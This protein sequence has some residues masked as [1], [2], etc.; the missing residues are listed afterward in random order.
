ML[1]GALSSAYFM[2][3]NYRLEREH[4]SQNAIASARALTS[5]VDKDLA[6]IESGLRVLSVSP[7]LLN[8]DL[9]TFYKFTKD[10]L[11]Y[12]NISNYVLLDPKGRQVLNTLRDFGEA[13]PQTGNPPV[14]QRI[15]DS[16]QTVLTDLFTG[17]V[18]GKPILAMGVPVFK[19]GQAIYSINVGIFPER[20]SALMMRQRLPSNWIC[21]ILDSEGKI[22]VESRAKLSQVSHPKLSH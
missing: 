6:S 7:S 10:A 15:F 14:L 20:L 3:E 19:D 13:L 21:A 9:S 17:P 12:Q 8:G 18:T 2:A 4:L 11:P 5:A 22:V 16:H 1:P